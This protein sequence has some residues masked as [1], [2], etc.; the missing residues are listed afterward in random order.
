MALPVALARGVSGWN[1]IDDPID[2]CLLQGQK[3][4]GIIEFPDLETKVRWDILQG[5]GWSGGYPIFRGDTLS[6]FSAILRLYTTKDWDD[7]N[8]WKHLL[9]KTKTGTRPQALSIWHP[10]LEIAEP[11][12]RAVV[13]KGWKPPTQVDDGVWAITISMMQ[14]RKPK[15]QYAAPQSAQATQQPDANQQKILQLMDQVQ[16]LSQ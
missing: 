5:P 4:P 11:P 6:E 10:I 2:Y 13:I 12:I 14:F 3:S 15:P 1:P 9:G 7:F 8:S 16:K